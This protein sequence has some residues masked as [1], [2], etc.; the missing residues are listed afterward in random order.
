MV[1]SW[2][3]DGQAAGMI[4]RESDGPIT[5]YYSRVV[6]HAIGDGLMPDAGTQQLWRAQRDV[7]TTAP[8]WPVPPG[9]SR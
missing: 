4:V 6:P 1:G 9:A 8:R 5:D 2:V 7:S 3:I